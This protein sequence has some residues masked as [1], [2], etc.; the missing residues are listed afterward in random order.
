MKVDGPNDSKKTAPGE[1]GRSLKVNGSKN[2]SVRP[3]R[4]KVDGLYLILWRVECIFCEVD[5]VLNVLFNIIQSQFDLDRRLFGDVGDRGAVRLL[6]LFLSSTC[7]LELSR[8]VVSSS[9][10]LIL[11]LPNLRVYPILLYQSYSVGL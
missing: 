8:I 6:S 1:C 10:T 4:C 3:K 7:I 9:V 5:I 2:E 11:P